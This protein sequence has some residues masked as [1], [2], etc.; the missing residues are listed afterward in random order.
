MAQISKGTLDARS[1]DAQIVDL[2]TLTTLFQFAPQLRTDGITSFTMDVSLARNAL[3]RVYDVVVQADRASATAVENV[4]QVRATPAE[5][6]L[7]ASIVLDFGTLR[8]VSG[9][10]VGS[11]M[12]I[13]GITPWI[14]ASFSPE[15]VF[16]IRGGSTSE[17]VV[18]LRK[19]IRTERLLVEVT[20]TPADG[21]LWSSM[22]VVLPEAPT[23]LEIRI[24][25]GAPVASFPGPAQ[26]GPD[27]TLTDQGWN[28]EGERIVHLGDAFAKLTG[29][30]TR[31]ELVTF[32]VVLSSRV[33]GEL[34]MA[35]LDRRVPADS[36]VT[37]RGGPPKISFVRR[38]RFN[39]DTTKE[40]VFQEEGLQEIQL[41]TLPADPVI[42]EITFTLAGTLPLERVIPPVGPDV[43]ALGP[44]NLGLADLLLGPDHAACV[45]LRSDTGLTELTAIRLPLIAGSG[46]AE[47][48]IVLWR[49]DETVG[50]EPLEPMTDGV[51]E[52]VTLEGAN[53]ETEIWTTFSFKRPVP[54]NDQAP[55]WAALLVSRGQ[56]VWSLGT[57]SGADDPIAAHV[58]RRGAPTGP[59][60]LLPKPFQDSNSALGSVRGRLR[61]VGYAPKD[62]PVAPLIVGIG[63]QTLEVTPT[64]KG[65]VSRLSFSPH[66]TSA[67]LTVVSRVAGSVTLRD[68]DVVTTA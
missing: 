1:L 68:L 60:K 65:V 49:P 15:K 14:G 24:D 53:T 35:V 20:G 44:E 52:P 23:D 62:R 12:S 59:W 10:L 42:E 38:V 40:L 48:R 9:V 63:S 31:D 19:E 61:V 18:V 4:A 66:M 17:E 27:G 22:G 11:P 21:E 32:K 2:R 29:D 3:V 7:P 54:I 25:G 26:P 41:A 6:T 28:N 56:V 47:A 64:A 55:P 43:P 5:G 45:R 34:S 39:D 13:V 30:P 8:T 33:P 57:V 58:I 67:N 46:S 36:G 51:S 50:Q 37:A 16:P